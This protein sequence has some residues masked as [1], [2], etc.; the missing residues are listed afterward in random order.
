MATRTRTVKPA[1]ADY[2]GGDP[3]ES[4][5]ISGGRL[6]LDPSGLHFIGP[7]GADLRQ[8]L[9]GLLGISISGRTAESRHGRGPRGTMRVAVL[10]GAQHAEWRF[11]IDRSAATALRRL[12]NRELSSR[13]RSPLPFV[14]E[15]DGFPLNGSHPEPEAPY[16]PPPRSPSLRHSPSPRTPSPGHSPSLQVSMAQLGHRL[17]TLDAQRQAR[18]RRRVLPWALLGA[19]LIAAEVIVPLILLRGG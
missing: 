5:L 4:R 7:A 2:L 12:V 13:G 18:R 10:R 11:A 8:P 19:A 9:D 15:L 14:E 16:S 6:G 1:R 3:G 17:N